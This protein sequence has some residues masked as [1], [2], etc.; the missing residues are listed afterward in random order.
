MNDFTIKHVAVVSLCTLLGSG[1]AI[2]HSSQSVRTASDRADVTRGAVFRSGKS[3]SA[4]HGVW[5]TR[6]RPCR[7][8]TTCRAERSNV[9][10]ILFSPHGREVDRD[11]RRDGRAEVDTIPIA[12]GRY[13]VEVIGAPCDTVGC[14]GQFAVAER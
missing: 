13:R 6:G 8:V 11:L 4:F 9:E 12:S 3:P 7:I 2:A 14:Q 1:D 10:M 5:L